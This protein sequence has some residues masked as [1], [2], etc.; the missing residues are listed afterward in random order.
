MG[1]I[2]FQQSMYHASA[3]F[4]PRW[5]T[6]RP[7]RRT[8]SLAGESPGACAPIRFSSRW[9]RWVWFL[10]TTGLP[11]GLHLLGRIKGRGRKM[12]RGNLNHQWK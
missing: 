2:P 7:A 1:D 11:V 9:R 3:D 6:H 10:G 8:S 5:M 12:E 4:A